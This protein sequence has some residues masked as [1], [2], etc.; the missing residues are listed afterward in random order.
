MQ[1][2]TPLK[3]E[4][5]MNMAALSRFDEESDEPLSEERWLPT[6]I[7]GNGGFSSMKANAAEVKCK[8][9]VPWVIIMPFGLFF[10]S[11]SISFAS[12]L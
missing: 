5:L 6:K 3:F 4:E 1:I 9:S 10:I 8:V 7:I 11:F 12:R 2:A